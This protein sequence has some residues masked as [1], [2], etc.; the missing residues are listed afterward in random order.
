MN[1]KGFTLVELIAVVVI[2]GIIAVIATPNIVNMI[3]NG[4]KDQFIADAKEMI[5]KAKYQ[6]K[7]DKYWENGVF[8]TEGDCTVTNAE[9]LGFVNMTDADGNS[10]VLSECK[11]KCALKIINKY[12]MS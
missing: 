2:I 6:I 4:K 7:L 1:K 9:K 8:E 3:D 11:V 5:S 10:Y 12:T